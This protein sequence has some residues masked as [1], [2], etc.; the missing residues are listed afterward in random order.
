[1]KKVYICCTVENNNNSWEKA[2]IRAN[3]YCRKAFDK[4][5][6]PVCPRIYLP[7]FLDYE[8]TGERRNAKRLSIKALAKCSEVWVFG[9]DISKGMRAEI[10]YAKTHNIKVIY[11]DYF[12]EKD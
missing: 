8:D 1:M 7:N 3:L 5:F 12:G 9:N 2:I 11:F 6:F 10:E 4:G